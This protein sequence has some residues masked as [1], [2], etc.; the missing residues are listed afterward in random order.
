MHRTAIN[1]PAL[2][3]PPSGRYS[4]AVRLDLTG[5]DLLFVSGQLA[6]EG[7]MTAQ[8]EQ[9]FE[10]LATILADQGATFDDVVNI[11]TYVTDMALLRDYGTVRARYLKADPPTSTTVEVSS[12]FR[13]GALVE[14]DLV[15]AVARA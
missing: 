15:A 4:H 5:A 7:D 10:A 13:A 6:T 14:V 1:P 12:L 11:R 9:V 8:S 3:A 2:P